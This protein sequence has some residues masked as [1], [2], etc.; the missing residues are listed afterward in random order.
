M[1][2]NLQSQPLEKKKGSRVH[3]LILIVSFLTLLN[4]LAVLRPAQKLEASNQ[5]L[6]YIEK[7]YFLL[8]A[9]QGNSLRP[10]DQPMLNENIVEVVITGYSST[11]WQTDDTP[12]ITAAGTSVRNGVVAA[13]FL[14]FGAKI[15]IPEIYGERTFIVE[16]RMHPRK[17]FQIDI[18]FEN[19]WQAKDFGIKQTYVE[20]LEG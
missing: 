14:P 4:I 9:I 19:Y 13:N 2:E 18:W 6:I 10:V 5:P 8:P 1:F 16:D 7:D 15:R 12:F 11:V 17:H 20:V 3:F